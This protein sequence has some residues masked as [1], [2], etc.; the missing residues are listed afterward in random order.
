MLCL[1]STIRTALLVLAATCAPGCTHFANI[2]EVPTEDGV[3]TYVSSRDWDDGTQRTI[4]T[5]RVF[6]R[7]EAPCDL[8]EIQREFFDE[9]GQLQYRQTDMETCREVLS[10]V[11]ED[12]DVRT[13]RVTRTVQ[14]DSDRDGLFDVARVE[15][16]SLGTGEV[17]SLLVTPALR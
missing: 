7:P 15:S 14:K 1:P 12:Y 4:V 8:L 6:E 5:E 17:A 10:R 2:S 3:T 11:T 13:G 16:A 9:T